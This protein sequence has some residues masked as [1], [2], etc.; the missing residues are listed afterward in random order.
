MGPSFA[1][2]TITV[3]SSN[4]RKAANPHSAVVQA[5]P[6]NAQVDIQSCGG[7]W[8]Y[9]S[10]RG[11]SGFLP[12]FAVAQGAPPPVA[13]PPVVYAAPAP[14]VVVTAPVVVDPPVHYWGGPYVGVGWGYGWGRW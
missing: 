7:D 6:A 9:G 1:D 8:C 14:P 4:M 12:S 11:R 10:W 5:V 3:A 13:P 2:P